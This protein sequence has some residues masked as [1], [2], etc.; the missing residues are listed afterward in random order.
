M[1]DHLTVSLGL[2][3]GAIRLPLSAAPDELAPWAERAARERLGA[4]A[5]PAVVAAFADVLT[6]AANDARTRRAVLAMSFC[7]D[8]ANGELARIEITGL[9][10][11]P[12]GS[13]TIRDV[14]E[15][16]AR[17]TDRSTGPAEVVYGDLPIGSAVRVR[18]Q[19][20]TRSTPSPEE[21]EGG[22]SG[23]DGE[24]VIVQTV[25][26][27]VLAPEL[28]HP[29]VLFVSWQALAYTDRLNALADKLAQ[30]MRVVPG[31]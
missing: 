24:G 21:W 12:D 23:D 28:A 22:D 27:G 6:S 1:S 17:P 30:T 9:T 10:G 16:L 5:D 7:P 25:A 26:H 19:Y 18:H 15:Y 14:A 4:D 20:V 2:P 29:V 11:F 8:P 13:P 31:D 3:G